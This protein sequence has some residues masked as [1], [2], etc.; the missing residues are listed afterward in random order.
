MNTMRKLNNLALFI[1]TSLMLTACSKHQTLP[2][3]LNNY[4]ERVYSVMDL[5]YESLSVDVD[6]QAPTK[7]E[8][9][10]SI[11]DLNIN[12]RE[13]YAIE[14][15]N[16]KTIIAERNTALGKTQLPSS[17]LLYEWQIIEALK[18]CE[19]NANQALPQ[20]LQLKVT[21]WRALKESSFGANWANMLTQSDESYLAFTRS[22][23]FIDGN[24]DDNFTQAKI[25]LNTLVY[26]ESDPKK[27]L[28][29][30]ENTLK[31]AE[32]HRFFARHWRSQILITQYMEKMTE[33]ISTWND[34]FICK[35]RK[36][37]KKLEI[38]KNVFT[39]FFVQEIQPIASQINHYQYQ[40]DDLFATLIKNDQLPDVFQE[41][42]HK[43]S[44]IIFSDYK[45]ATREH[46]ELWQALLSKC[47]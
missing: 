29:N 11:A 31:S 43:K 8:L 6:L 40:L 12:M 14:G 35:S 30:L 26:A 39:L 24:N 23:G 34:S 46:V 19:L 13:F 37:K 9:R 27:Y 45:K 2:S 47:K 28:S 32:Q 25:D 7:S 4:H 15:C 21:E 20:Y 42:L 22:G 16:L 10:R 3:S 44:S 1:V 33:D 38:I 5:P 17:R 36:D 41:W 18:A